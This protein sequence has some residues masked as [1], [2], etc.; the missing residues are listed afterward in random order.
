[1]SKKEEKPLTASEKAAACNATLMKQAAERR[2]APKKDAGFILSPAK[3][4]ER[5]DA[6]NKGLREWANKNRVGSQPG[7][8]KEVSGA[9][10]PSEKGSCRRKTGHTLEKVRG[11]IERIARDFPVDMPQAKG[12]VV[13]AFA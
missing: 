3:M 7:T 9:P 6:Y 5:D 1:M 13:G 11:L 4:K 12:V 10:V 2:N 8:F